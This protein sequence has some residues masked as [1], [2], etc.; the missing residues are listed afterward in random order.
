MCLLHWRNINISSAVEDREIKDCYCK[1]IP[2]MIF[3]TSYGTLG[4]MASI[5]LEGCFSL[6]KPEI[7]MGAF[8]ELLDTTS[9]TDHENIQILRI[10]YLVNS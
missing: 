2:V 3:L 9:Y 1:L 8:S 4:Q 10:L 6:Q 5:G 7:V